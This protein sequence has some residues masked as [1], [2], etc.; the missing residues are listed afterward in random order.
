MWE[1]NRVAVKSILNVHLFIN[2]SIAKI[3]NILAP[4]SFQ[5]FILII[6]SNFCKQTLVGLYAA[7][8]QAHLK[9]HWRINRTLYFHFIRRT[10]EWQFHVLLSC[11]IVILAIAL[12]LR[13]QW[14]YKSPEKWMTQVAGKNKAYLK[15]KKTASFASTWLLCLARTSACVL[16][17]IL[18]C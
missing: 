18:M 17:V 8:G 12:R 13:S 6:N 1:F 14:N 7:V 11:C 5:P 15:E 16:A 2:R 4:A 3:E 9:S 10:N